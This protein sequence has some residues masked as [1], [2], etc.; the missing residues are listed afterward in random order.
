MRRWLIYQRERLPLLF[1]AP[2]SLGLTLSGYY[3]A[4]GSVRF[5]P[6]CIG[7]FAM[8]FYG[9]YLRLSDDMED[10]EQDVLAHPE[11]PLPRKLL[12][13]DEVVN[14]LKWLLVGLWGLVLLLWLLTTFFAALSFAFALLWGMVKIFQKS[15]HRLM[16]EFFGQGYS[17]FLAL[18]SLGLG[19]EGL[20]NL[21]VL[22]FFPLLIFGSVLTYDITRKLN[23]R[24][25]PIL[26]TP[27]HFYGLAKTL[28]FLFSVLVMTAIGAGAL[29]FQMMLWPIEIGVA[30]SAFAVKLRSEW[31]KV[32]ENVALF[33]LFIH[34]YA[35]LLL[36]G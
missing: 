16:T 19:Y 13:L 22:L 36:K 33:S 24:A 4:A 28:S 6:V 8:L 27:I 17:F 20:F 11:R 9:F 15:S 18:F 1:Y 21:P 32:P 35:P 34:V 2:L 12:S 5:L 30:A 26:M 14:G 31:Y 23:P 29:G 10:F 25:H 3:L 7:F